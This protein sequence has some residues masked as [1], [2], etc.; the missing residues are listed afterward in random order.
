MN[1][2]IKNPKP[3]NLLAIIILMCMLST[4][5]FGQLPF[6]LHG[7]GEAGIGGRI[8]DDPE[9]ERTSLLE[10]RFQVDVSREFDIA[11]FRLRADLLYDHVADSYEIVIEEGKGFID[12]REANITFYP[13]ELI[14]IKF[15]R[16]ILTWGTGDMIFIN[17]LF[18]KDWQSFFI[19]RDHEYLKAPS[20]GLRTSFFFDLINIDMV[21]IPNFDSDR[22]INGER[23]SYWNNTLREISGQ[24]AVTVADRPDKWFYDYEFAL[25]IYK[26]IDSIELALYG[27]NGF[28]KS[29]N[30]MDRVNGLAIFPE[31]NVI[32]ASARGNI[33]K[34]I[35]NFESGYYYSSDDN[36][37]GNPFIRNSELRLL[38]GYERELLKELTLGIQYYLE[39]MLHYNTYKNNSLP[40]I[41]IKDEN[42]HLLTLRITRM[43]LNQNLKLSLFIFCSPSDKDIYLRPNS[44]YKVTDS[45]AV[46]LGGNIFHGSHDYTFFGQFTNNDNFYV[47]AKYGF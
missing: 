17:D 25:R 36:G 43:A 7:F 19:G 42:R 9:E 30:G 41:P 16:Q 39:H 18:P 1:K 21:Y 15:G 5:L 31:L 24:N 46:E 22:F 14:D 45:L 26:N 10:G 34:G 3:I 2:K 28:W 27:Y 13:M 44:N 8:A 20:D 32:G 35:G 47:K 6:E 12:L 37:G 33:L 40:G 29:P 38:W 4:S 23:I 11:E